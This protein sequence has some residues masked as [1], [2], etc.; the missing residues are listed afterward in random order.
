MELSF[1]RSGGAGG[2]NVNKVNTKVD[3]RV[4]LDNANWLD[5]EVKEA[6]HAPATTPATTMLTAVCQHAPRACKDHSYA[7]LR[8]AA[9]H[10]KNELLSMC[11]C[12]CL[13]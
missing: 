3:M 12:R 4:K 7:A 6:V 11:V 5:P 1:A 8:C 9:L 13:L 10:L 2:Q